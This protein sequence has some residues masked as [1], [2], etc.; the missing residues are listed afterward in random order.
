MSNQFIDSNAKKAL[1]QMKLE[2]SSEITRES[3]I[4][5]DNMPIDSIGI[6]ARVGGQMSKK[7]VEIG[8]KELLK[9]YNKDT[10]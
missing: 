1:D 5:N 4:L 6:S 9:K 2:I 10:L 7:L 3:N 8:E